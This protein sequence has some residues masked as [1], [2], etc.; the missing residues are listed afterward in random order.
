MPA[1]KVDRSRQEQR[2][3]F[4]ADAFTLLQEK[5]QNVESAREDAH[6]TV[7]T[8]QKCANAMVSDAERAKTRLQKE[9]DDACLETREVTAKL[10][11][12]LVR[13]DELEAEDRACR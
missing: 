5:E 11:S 8:A 10:D 7:E 12:A 2:E 6:R 9:L 1:H 4:L 13:I 3:D